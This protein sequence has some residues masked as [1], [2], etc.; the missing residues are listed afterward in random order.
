MHRRRAGTRFWDLASPEIL[1]QKP[2]VKLAAY[3]PKALVLC[4]FAKLAIATGLC[5]RQRGGKSRHPVP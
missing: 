2:D 3:F 4:H 1:P 5:A